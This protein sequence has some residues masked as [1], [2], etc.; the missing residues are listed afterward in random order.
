M[1]EA[2]TWARADVLN[3]FSIDTTGVKSFEDISMFDPTEASAKLLAVTIL[4]QGDRSEAEFKELLTEI[5]DDIAKDGEW[6]NPEKKKEI[7]TWA[8]DA[9]ES[10]RL[11]EIREHIVK[12]TDVELPDFIKYIR[13]FWQKELSN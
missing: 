12:G 13:N 6:D 2:K 9:D 10:G 8:K 11:N 4:L 7:A 5:A 1:K 3:L